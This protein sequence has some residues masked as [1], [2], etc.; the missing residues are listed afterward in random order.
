M[1]VGFIDRGNGVTWPEYAT[2]KHTIQWDGEDSIWKIESRHPDTQRV[3][4][5]WWAKTPSFVTSAT[6]VFGLITERQ[7]L[8]DFTIDR[9]I[10]GNALRLPYV[11][12]GL[13]K[14]KRVRLPE[15]PYIKT[16]FYRADQRYSYRVWSYSLPV[17][18]ECNPQND[19]GQY[20]SEYPGVMTAYGAYPTFNSGVTLLDANDEIKLVNRL[21]EKTRGS[22]F[23]PSVFVGEIDQSL[24]MISNAATRIAT[25]LS[26][27]K[28]AD[29]KGAVTALLNIPRSD[30]RLRSDAFGRYERRVQRDAYGEMIREDLASGL[31][32][33]EDL[34]RWSARTGAK[35]FG[36]SE[37]KVGK[38]D[39]A[40]MRARY[41]KWLA[42]PERDLSASIPKTF[43][44]WWLEIS[45]GWLPL[46]SDAEDSAKM[47]AHHL[48]VPLQTRVR[49]TIKKKERQR[50]V[51]SWQRCDMLKTGKQPSY[52]FPDE[53]AGMEYAYGMGE[54]LHRVALVAKWNEREN[55]PKLLGLTTL[56]SVAWELT[57]WS[58]V[59]DWFIPIGDWLAARGFAQGLQGTFIRSAKRSVM[60]SAPFGDFRYEPGGSGHAG[61]NCTDFTRTILPT[62]TVPKP[63]SKPLSK[64]LSWRH[65][66]NAV[67]L[68]VSGNSQGNP[69]T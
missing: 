60:A 12:N 47:L 62:L 43:S 37:Q 46:L 34:H 65:C 59:V 14:P 31:L 45:Y 21:A 38:R 56:E 30:P 6:N 42:D 57:P 13:R 39:L 27:L 19:S 67:A 25:A 33:P 66:A 16:C 51:I 53:V 9:T 8:T 29:A 63:V 40:A 2:L 22:D 1:T 69:R 7:R 18:A 11:P 26:R 41:K 5:E 4:R 50:K 32:K 55:V 49:A 64:S 20:L 28:R 23:N 3:T 44:Q 48:D 52:W 54:I 10:N 61:K 17:D 58:F 35:A 15:N 68:L 24:R 36:F